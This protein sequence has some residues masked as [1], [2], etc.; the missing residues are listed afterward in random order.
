MSFQSRTKKYCTQISL[1]FLKAKVHFL[2]KWQHV[3]FPQ[4]AVGGD[5]WV[6]NWRLNFLTGRNEVESLSWCKKLIQPGM[7]V[8]DVGAHLGY[9][10]RVTSNLVGQKG[11]ILA[12]EPC[13][14]NWPVLKYNIQHLRYGNVRISE[15]AVSAKDGEAVLFISP[16]HSNH[17]LNDG[18]TEEQGKVEVGTV[19]LDTF[20]P[21]QGITRVDF[22]K[23]DVE[24]A[25]PLVLE[26]MR[27]IVN[28][29]PNLFMLVEYNPI[30]L[31]A[32]K[33]DPPGLLDILRSMGMTPRRI[34]PNGDLGDVD[35]SSDETINLLCIPSSK[36]AQLNE[37]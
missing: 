17:S 32:G 36:L 3:R 13:P 14:E 28:A 18:Y 25:E 23:I 15:K 37:I 33:F 19:A 1:I 4:R 10:T 24:G 30:A 8:V 22:I 11:L 26:G 9:Y 34:L 12:F 16:G 20:L 6:Y 29:S 5:Q 27:N 21:S 2:M 31:R 35:L 7:V